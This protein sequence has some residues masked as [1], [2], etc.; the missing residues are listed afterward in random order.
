VGAQA[1]VV[2]GM[3]SL[4]SSLLRHGGLPDDALLLLLDEE[5]LEELALEE[6]APPA[7]P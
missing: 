2:Q 3:P 5:A 7:P 6:P 1:S 4:Q